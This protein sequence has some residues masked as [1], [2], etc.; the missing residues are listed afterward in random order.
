MIEKETHSLLDR[1]LE[2]SARIV[3][4]VLLLRLA[5][6]MVQ[7]L[8]PI[9]IAVVAIGTAISIALWYYRSRW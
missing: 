1:A 3:G 9:F 6:A 5:L 7:P 4:V 8:I 2:V